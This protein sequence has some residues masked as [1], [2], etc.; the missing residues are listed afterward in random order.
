MTP[1]TLR[2]LFLAG[3]AAS[4][5]VLVVR[6]LP[7]A[8]RVGPVTHRATG[9]ARWLPFALLPVGFL[10]PP[11]LLLTRTGEVQAG[12]WPVRIAG[13]VCAVY[14]TGMLLG[15]AGTLGRM[16]VP[17]AVVRPDHELV[18]RG[19]YALVRHPAYSGDLALWFGAAL[20]T[21]NLAL[22]ALFPLYV[23]GARAQAG[24]EEHVLTERFGDAYADYSR[25]VGRF[26]PRLTAPAAGS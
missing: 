17:Q 22:L 15:S 21:L 1:D 26:L 4:V 24:V 12:W 25:R 2:T 9:P 5:L 6:V 23:L 11:V 20:A 14:A 19:P 10:V 16:L 8:A 3:Y 7:A 18:T 13:I